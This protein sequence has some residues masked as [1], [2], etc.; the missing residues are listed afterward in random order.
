MS[1][2]YFLVKMAT[3]FRVIH[4]VQWLLK[5]KVLIKWEIQISTQH[6]SGAEIWF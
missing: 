6:L 2:K 3:L 1:L 4:G 5:Y